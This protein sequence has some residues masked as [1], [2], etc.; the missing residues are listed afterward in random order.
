MFAMFLR[1][2]WAVEK[3]EIEAVRLL[4]LATDMTLSN[5]ALDLKANPLGEYAGSLQRANFKK[6][7]ATVSRT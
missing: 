5:Q 1:H 3:D 2:G 4:V 6:S 7:S